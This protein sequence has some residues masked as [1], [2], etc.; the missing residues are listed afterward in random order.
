MSILCTVHRT[1]YLL[2]VYDGQYIVNAVAKIKAAATYMLDKKLSNKLVK[3]DKRSNVLLG[4]EAF[5]NKIVSIEDVAFFTSRTTVENILERVDEAIRNAS[6][7]EWLP[8]A[9]LSTEQQQ[10]RNDRMVLNEENYKLYSTI[11]KEQLC[12]KKEQHI[13][14]ETIVRDDL[15]Q[16]I[17]RISKQTKKEKKNDAAVPTSEV[18]AKRGKKKGSTQS[19]Q[20]DQLTAMQEALNV[21]VTQLKDKSRV[22]VQGGEES[23]TKDTVVQSQSKSEGHLQS[24]LLQQQVEDLQ[25]KLT[26]LISS[27]AIQ[28][29]KPHNSGNSQKKKRV[30]RVR[31]REDEADDDDEAS[32]YVPSVDGEKDVVSAVTFSNHA[33]SSEVLASEII[34]SEVNDCEFIA[35]ST[36]NITAIANDSNEYFVDYI[37]NDFKKGTQEQN[38]FAN[39]FIAALK[40]TAQSWNKH[41]TSTARRGDPLNSFLQNAIEKIIAEFNFSV[42]K[43]KLLGLLGTLQVSLTKQYTV[44][45]LAKQKPREQFLRELVNSF[46]LLDDSTNLSTILEAIDKMELIN[47]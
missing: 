27:S 33:S 18:K 34:G 40:S 29:R 4:A 47:C 22:A 5:R 41:E 2:K 28:K 37:F 36:M 9:T 23:Q 8:K 26:N 10:K 42:Y 16:L 39:K 17:K 15:N 3:Y 45:E 35:D 19:S 6:F 32:S 13:G 14:S 7:F 46:L 30:Q 1:S 25:S 21:L 20:E 38:E 44:D 11:W 43:L 31:I 24:S 12:S